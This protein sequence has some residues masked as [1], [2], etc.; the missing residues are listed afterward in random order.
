MLV[1]YKVCKY[2]NLMH[3]LCN[4]PCNGEGSQS[5]SIYEQGAQT[6]L[7]YIITYYTIY[8]RPHWNMSSVKRQRWHVGSFSFWPRNT[9]W[10]FYQAISG[11][12]TRIKLF[13]QLNF[14]SRWQHW[15]LKQMA[16]PEKKG[17]SRNTQPRIRMGLQQPAIRWTLLTTETQLQGRSVYLG[18]FLYV[19]KVYLRTFWSLNSSPEQ[20]YKK[21]PHYIQCYS[22]NRYM[23]STWSY[24]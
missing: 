18:S 15:R 19:N 3:H 17:G 20:H 22:E 23:N 1:K 10:I 7:I 2:K 9:C 21:R 13:C 8:G 4:G 14:W 16:E 6:W 12:W 24:M 11:S 5:R